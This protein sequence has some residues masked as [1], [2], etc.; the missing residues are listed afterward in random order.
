MFNSF[1]SAPYGMQNQFN[2]QT[3]P[4][5]KQEVIRVNGK[6]GA[7]ALNLPPNSSVLLLDENEPVVWLKVTDGAGYPS[8]T[9]Y[10]ITPY[11]E[12]E[13]ID[14]TSLESRI[15]RLEAK[16]N[17]SNATDSEQGK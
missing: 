8:L 16:L 1:P 10:S 9:A 6:N 2:N 13:P 14:L 7:A 12:K 4:L 15:T 17:E 5:Q 11:K 3:Y